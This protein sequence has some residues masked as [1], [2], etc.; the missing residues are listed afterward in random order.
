MEDKNKKEI[1]L[2]PL[3]EIIPNRFQPRLAFDEKELNDLANS[4]IKYGVIQPIVVRKI[5]EKYEIIAGERRYKASTIAG[6][7]KI[8]AIINNTDDNTSAEIALLENLQR[9]NLTVIEEA[10]SFKKLMDRGFKQ[11]T[12]A[13]KLGISQS[14]IANKIRLLSLPKSV[15]NS[16]LYNKIS[17]RHARSL[18][19]LENEE[20][21]EELLKRI[22]NEKL[23]VKQTEDEVSKILN[24]GKEPEEPEIEIFDPS[25]FTSSVRYDSEPPKEYFNP[26]V[27]KENVSDNK[28]EETKKILD[29]INDKNSTGEGLVDDIEILPNIEAIPDVYSQINP[30]QNKGLI[31]QMLDNND[32]PKEKIEE[33]IKEEETKYNSK[34]NKTVDRIR[35]CIKELDINK[36]SVKTT[37]IDLDNKYRIIIEIDKDAV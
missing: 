28:L 18:L 12:I 37:E 21:Q 23:T 26:N 13:S 30:F 34:L 31:D 9:K 15:Q 14:S 17:E 22:V 24:K 11:E 36:E 33:K 8:P 1:V 2:I 6:I 32:M 19:T 35:N 10:K 25:S 4:I 5:G 16:L 7:K 27:Y 20:Q 29:S 3:D